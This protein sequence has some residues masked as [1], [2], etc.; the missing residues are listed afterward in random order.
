MLGGLA[1]AHHRAWAGK[2]LQSKSARKAKHVPK[3][4]K[5][6][7]YLA[8]ENQKT[9]ALYCQ[10]RIKHLPSQATS[11]QV[12][13]LM[14]NTAPQAVFTTRRLP[15]RLKRHWVEEGLTF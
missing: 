9:L 10:K 6:R 4:L 14:R 11:E 2:R 8:R 13:R 15:G 12:K 1:P 7:R 3:M 5:I